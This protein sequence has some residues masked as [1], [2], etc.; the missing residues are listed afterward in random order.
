MSTVVLSICSAYA[1]IYSVQT[2]AGGGLPENTPCAAADLGFVTGLAA[3]PA[4]NV[5]IPLSAYNIVVRCDAAAGLLTRVAGTRAMGFS[6]GQNVP[7]TGVARRP[8][9]H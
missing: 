2:V 7:A 8:S 5:F 4:G 6:D 1:Q 3:D 9:A